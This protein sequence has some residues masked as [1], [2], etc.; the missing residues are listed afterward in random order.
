M[1]SLFHFIK[2]KFMIGFQIINF[3]YTNIY[4]NSEGP[5]KRRAISPPHLNLIN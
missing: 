5:L 4:S 1:D 3:I 2:K